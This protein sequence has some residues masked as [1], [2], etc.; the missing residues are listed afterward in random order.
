MKNNC[1]DNCEVPLCPLDC[2]EKAQWFPDEAICNSRAIARPSWI[3]TQRKIQKLFSK[4]HITNEECFTIPMLQG[5][6][7]VGKGLHG[8]KPE[9]LD[10]NA[11]LRR[12]PS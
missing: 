6:Q 12:C 5:I 11:T 10:K 8:M 2:H 1:F 3:K 9:Y 4:G 7:R